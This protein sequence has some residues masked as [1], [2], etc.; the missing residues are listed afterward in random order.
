MLNE[1]A[2]NVDEVP[3]GHFGYNET[4]DGVDVGG[5]RCTVG[6]D[7]D[8]SS[9]YTS[10]ALVP[11]YDSNTASRTCHDTSGVVRITGRNAYVHRRNIRTS[12]EVQNLGLEDR[13]T[14][15]TTHRAP[16]KNRRSQQTHR[17]AL[18]TNVRVAE[19][20]DIWPASVARHGGLRGT[21]RLAE[22]TVIPVAPALRHA[23]PSLYILMPA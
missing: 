11:L 6:T 8:P 16:R 20:T 4:D 5:S 13:G 22:S 9:L 7:I 15:G 3:L 1:V 10:N 12:A 2:V 17:R 19:G 18:Y 14:A 23:G 21:A